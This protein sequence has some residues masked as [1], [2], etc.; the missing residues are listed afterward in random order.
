MPIILNIDHERKEAHAV[1]TGPIHYADIETHLLAEG[2]FQGLPYRELFDARDATLMFSLSP[3]EIRSIV[4]LVRT[5]SK[6]SKLGPTAVIVA[7]DFA[8]GIMHIL[9]MLLEDVA[10]IKPFRDEQLARAWLAAK[11]VEG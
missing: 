6:E 1:A 2:N 10:E 9:E 8:F 4:A 3:S 7:D 5:L 11:S